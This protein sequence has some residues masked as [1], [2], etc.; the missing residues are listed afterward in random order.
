MSVKQ[1]TYEERVTVVLVFVLIF[2]FSL[3]AVV[4]Y[5]TLFCGLRGFTETQKVKDSETVGVQRTAFSAFQRC[6]C[7]LVAFITGAQAFKVASIAAINLSLTQYLP[8][9]I[10]YASLSGD[11]FFCPILEFFVLGLTCLILAPLSDCFSLKVTAIVCLLLQSIDYLLLTISASRFAL[12]FAELCFSVTSFLF[13]NVC[14]SWMVQEHQYRGFRESWF[15]NTYMLLILTLCPSVFICGNVSAQLYN[16]KNYAT[17]FLT[18]LCSSVLITVLCSAL[19]SE[20]LNYK[21]KPA[22]KRLLPQYRK[23]NAYSV[24]LT[25]SRTLVD[26]CS[27]LLHFEVRRF[28]KMTVCITVS[29]V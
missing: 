16:L 10:K 17:L 27:T 1:F 12:F 23:L 5:I 24:A 9:A 29:I 6:Y 2:L 19:W 18:G 4:Q 14:D 26:A 25:A 15:L 3:R 13:Y 20:T 22:W 7:A 11:E 28:P 8:K 21:F